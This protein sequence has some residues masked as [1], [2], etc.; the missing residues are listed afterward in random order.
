M[1]FAMTGVFVAGDSQDASAAGAM[2]T[3]TVFVMICTPQGMKRVALSD[4]YSDASSND[5]DTDRSGASSVTFQCP[6]HQF[7]S[8][9]A[10][11]DRV[12][13]DDLRA[14]PVNAVAHRATVERVPALSLGVEGLQS[15]APPA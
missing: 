7:F 14:A 8:V 6:W 9:G 2:E 15:R 12:L 11:P 10:L 4:L 13:T 5:G 3:R 1:Q